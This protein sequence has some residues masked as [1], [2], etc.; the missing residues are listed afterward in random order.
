MSM[1]YRRRVR[2][3]VAGIQEAGWPASCEAFYSEYRTAGHSASGATTTAVADL[4]SS[5]RWRKQSLP[6]PRRFALVEPLGTF[7]NIKSDAAARQRGTSGSPGGSSTHHRRAAA[8][9]GYRLLPATRLGALG[10]PCLSKTNGGGWR[11]GRAADRAAGGRGG[12]RVRR[13]V[14]EVAVPGWR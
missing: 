14:V 13:R 3:T 9:R 5:C 7:G 11:G 4:P 1:Y 12:R 2:T 6:N 8:S 10:V